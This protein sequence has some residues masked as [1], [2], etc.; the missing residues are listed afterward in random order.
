MVILG[1]EQHIVDRLR[2]RISDEIAKT[3]GN[4]SSKQ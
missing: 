2:E 4:Q 3:K 1:C